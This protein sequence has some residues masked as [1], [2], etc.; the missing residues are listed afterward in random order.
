[1]KKIFPIISIL[2]MTCSACINK[3]DY[4][5]D[6]EEDVIIMNALLRTDEKVHEVWV[7]VGQLDNIAVPR[8][9]AHVKC[10]INGKF[11]AEAEF[12]RVI[13][14]AKRFKFFADIQPGDEVQLKASV[15][16][17]QASATATAPQAA[18]IVAV[19]TFHVEKSPYFLSSRSGASAFGCRLQ[20]KD[21]PGQQNWYRLLAEYEHRINDGVVL[22]RNSVFEF[23]RD[24]IL[25]DIYPPFGEHGNPF[26][27]LVPSNDKNVFCAFRDTGFADRTAEVEVHMQYDQINLG[28][29]F[30]SVGVYVTEKVLRFILL[31]ISQE[32]Y[33]YLVQINK[34]LYTD[35]SFNVLQEPVRIPSNVENGLG[36]FSIATASSFEITRAK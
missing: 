4:Q 10:Y 15:G 33:D 19:D 35:Q 20:V 5:S 26:D 17:I 13:T 23:Y 28:S 1:M 16:S 9:D 36:F 34:S 6:L 12:D 14:G 7:S 30:G 27:G 18:Q 29:D 2:V 3:L 8:E 24:P 22:H 11:I 32:E 31:S 21:N 25:Q